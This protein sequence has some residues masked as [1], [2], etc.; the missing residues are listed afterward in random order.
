MGIRVWIMYGLVGIVGTLVMF[1]QTGHPFTGLH[2]LDASFDSGMSARLY[3]FA[4]GG[5]VLNMLAIACTKLSLKIGPGGPATA[6]VGSASVGLFML[7]SY[8]FPKPSYNVMEIVGLGIAILEVA[9]ISGVAK[10]AAEPQECLVEDVSG[11]Q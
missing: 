4:V 7:E 5:G 1:M 6:I 11:S 3:Y 9:V 10:G 8:F 2:D